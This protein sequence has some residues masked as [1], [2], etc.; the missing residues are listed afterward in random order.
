MSDWQEGGPPQIPEAVSHTKPDGQVKKRQVVQVPL[1]QVPLGALHWLLDVQP[2]GWREQRPD[3][4]LHVCPDGHPRVRQL[5][6]RPNRQVPLGGEHCESDTQPGVVPHRPELA[7]QVVPV[8]HWK[9]VLQDLQ[10][11]PWQLPVGGWH[12]VSD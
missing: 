11:P 7:L 8:G 2:G 12:S 1:R 9:S 3:T 5:W 4:A 6:H 10:V